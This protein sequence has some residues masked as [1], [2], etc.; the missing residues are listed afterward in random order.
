MAKI[1]TNSK[2]AEQAET[3]LAVALTAAPPSGECPS[4]EAISAWHEGKLQ[5]AEGEHVQHHVANCDRC[6]VLWTG[7]LAADDLEA[8]AAPDTSGFPAK[9]A[10]WLRSMMAMPS[11]ALAAGVVA[12]IAGGLIL[13]LLQTEM[14]PIPGYELTLDGV[15]RVTR[16]PGDNTDSVAIFD[17]G[18]RFSL[19]LTPETAVAD[20]LD[21]RLYIVKDGSMQQLATPG[22]R[23]SDKGV[24]QIEGIVGDDIHLPLGDAELLVVIGYKR[25]VPDPDT[26]RSGL[27]Q[28]KAVKFEGWSGWS[29][30]TRVQK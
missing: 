28:Q 12:V 7:L 6:Y 11:P 10:T 30:A 17:Q 18:N 5:N 29:I 9:L 2:R 4:D 25:H 23:L 14:Q 20:T 22:I 19:R 15:T 3:L 8:D 1:P 27:A 21:A 13:N 26:I 24:L 16:G